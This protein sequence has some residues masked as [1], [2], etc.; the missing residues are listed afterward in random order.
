[1]YDTMYTC[2]NMINT[3]HDDKNIYLFTIHITLIKIK[4]KRKF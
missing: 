1:M 3:G 4:Y 2:K